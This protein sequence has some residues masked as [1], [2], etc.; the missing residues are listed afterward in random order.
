LTIMFVVV[1]T[2]ILGFLNILDSSAISAIFGGI[3]GYV[4]GSI[5]AS[6]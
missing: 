4:L 5:K 6:R 3:V 1:F 2:G